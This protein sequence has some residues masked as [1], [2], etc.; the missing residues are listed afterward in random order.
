MKIR[1]INCKTA[2]SPSKLPGIDYSLNPYTGCEHSCA[3][4]YAPNVLK[5]NREKWGDFVYVKL[6]IPFILSRELRMKK[7]G[8]VGISTVTDPYQPVEKKFKITRYCLEQLLKHDFPINIQTKSS[9]ANRDIDL[10]SKFSNAEVMVSIPTLNDNERQL[11]EPYS[12]SIEERLDILRNYSNAG[13]RVC[14]FFGP[15]YPTIKNEEITEILKIFTDC[16]VSEIMIDK[17]HFRRGIIE[18]IKSALAKNPDLLEIFLKNIFKTDKFYSKFR[19][20]I[21]GF[22]RKNKIKIIDAF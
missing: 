22:S 11:L 4:C 15:I 12:S 20:N 2:L 8:V 10:I 1:Q 6:N 7:R 21:K 13:V 5:I 17:F 3:Y 18:N 16:G 14:V 19:K 9:I